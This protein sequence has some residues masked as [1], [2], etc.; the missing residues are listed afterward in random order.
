VSALGDFLALVLPRQIEA[1]TAMHNGDPAPRLAM[2]SERDPVT[3]LGAADSHR[4]GRDGVERVSRWIASKFSGCAEYRFELI[5]AGVSGDLAYTVGFERYVASF[6]GRPPAPNVLRV[7][8]VYRRE[9]GEW[10]IVHR[11]G[12][13]PPVGQGPADETTP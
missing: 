5:A 4:A 11:H 3:V 6:D 8:H 10:R 13:H 2:W 12:D 1:E 9:D 7:T